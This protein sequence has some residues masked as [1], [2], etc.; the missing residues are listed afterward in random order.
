M[1]DL[2][3][4]QPS[5]N[6]SKFIWCRLQHIITE[7]TDDRQAWKWINMHWMHRHIPITICIYDAAEIQ[8]DDFTRCISCICLNTYQL[9][10][11]DGSNHT[12][13]LNEWN[14]QM[15]WFPENLSLSLH[16]KRSTTQN[17]WLFISSCYLHHLHNYI[18]IEK[19]CFNP[20][21]GVLSW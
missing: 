21:E 10:H 18:P 3:S 2:S 20:K 8:I 5:H 16:T 9:I 11:T 12:H 4:V 1:L 15:N 7:C 17:S 13:I 14:I 19:K 6:I